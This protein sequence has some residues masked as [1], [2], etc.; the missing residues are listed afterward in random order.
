MHTDFSS[1]YISMPTRPCSRPKP[2]CLK[3][4]NGMFASTGPCVFTHTVP[5]RIFGIRRWTAVKSFDQMLAESPYCVSFASAGYL[6]EIVESLGN[7]D[8]TEN[9]L[10]HDSHRLLHVR[11]YGGLH[12]VA[13]MRQRSPP[14][15]TAAPSER[16][17]SM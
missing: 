1:V 8:R 3:P 2:E 4:P 12:V 5:A 15:T 16:P 7:D 10:L 14:V 11:H 6:I 13:R 9:L 17:D